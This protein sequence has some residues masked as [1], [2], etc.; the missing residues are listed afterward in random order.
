MNVL[1]IKKK[2]KNVAQ[3][4]AFKDKLNDMNWELIKKSKVY[5]ECNVKFFASQIITHQ[6]VQKKNL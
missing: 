3:F 6:R 5:Y 1:K 2:Q 4:G